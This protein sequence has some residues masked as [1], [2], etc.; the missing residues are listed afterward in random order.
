[1]PLSIFSDVTKRIKFKMA[2]MNKVI[3]TLLKFLN[4]AIQ[5]AQRGLRIKKNKAYA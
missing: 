5:I 4:S 2:R 3:L 1:M